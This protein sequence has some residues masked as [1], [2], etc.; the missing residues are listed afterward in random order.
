MHY[1]D[2]L[3]AGVNT[4]ASL[5]VRTVAGT[6]YGTWTGATESAIPIPPSP[7]GPMPYLMKFTSIQLADKNGVRTSIALD[8][9]VAVRR[10]TS[11]EMRSE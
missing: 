2:F 7:T 6:F 10:A 4:G 3:A 8:H 1:N 5:S 9:I 11:E